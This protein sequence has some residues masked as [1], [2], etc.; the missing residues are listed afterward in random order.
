[1][2]IV[3]LD[4]IDGDHVPKEE[5]QQELTEIVTGK[6]KVSSSLEK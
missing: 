6:G 1:M 4:K 3:N 2:Q 5:G